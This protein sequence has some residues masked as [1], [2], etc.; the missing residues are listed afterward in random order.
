MHG[1]HVVVIGAGA[2]TFSRQLMANATEEYGVQMI[3]IDSDVLASGCSDNNLFI[4]YNLS[5]HTRDDEHAAAI[6]DLICSRS[7]RVDGCLTF[8]GECLPLVAIICQQLNLIGPNVLAA[9]TMTRRSSTMD[10]LL[11][12]TLTLPHEP[13]TCLYATPT[14]RVGS[15]KEIADVSIKM[16]YPFVVKR[17]MSPSLA[18]IV[19][20]APSAYA[21]FDRLFES[22]AAVADENESPDAKLEMSSIVVMP[23]IGGTE[24]TVIIVLYHRCL[25]ASYVVDIAQGW[26]GGAAGALPSFLPT[27]RVAQ[28][29]IAARQCCVSLGLTD[30]IF[31]VRLRTS[32]SGPKLI[33]VDQGELGD[34]YVRDWIRVA[35]SVDLLLARLMIHCGV[36]PVLP[37]PRPGRRPIYIVG[38]NVPS[39]IRPPKF[40]GLAEVLEIHGAVRINR[41]QRDADED[42]TSHVDLNGRS[43]WCN[44][45]VA[46]SDPETAE[47]RLIEYTTLLGIASTEFD[48]PLLL[49]RVRHGDSA[50]DDMLVQP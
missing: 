2:E 48:M 16:S 26:T 30:G 33:G 6:C 39:T 32:A 35:Y 19:Y 17:D 8:D 5:D 44:V 18:T 28:L 24:H 37:M 11:A 1:K 14:Y 13:R 23:Y 45:A 49:R 42:P 7:L 22:A 9:K 4:Q 29:R 3:L 36:R 38:V 25:I 12:Q 40:K 31:Y 34:F 27:D 15:K 43:I 20:D 46:D 21:A 47:N 41:L 10:T 50:V